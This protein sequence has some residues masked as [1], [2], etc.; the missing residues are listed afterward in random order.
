M[1]VSY[2]QVRVNDAYFVTYRLLTARYTVTKDD[3]SWHFYR[4]ALSF[5]LNCNN[6]FPF[7][8]SFASFK[9]VQSIT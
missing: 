6:N 1:N 8:Y 9:C 5:L 4:P 3:Y 7:C 2:H